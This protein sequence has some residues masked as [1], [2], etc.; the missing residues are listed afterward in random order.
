VVAAPGYGKTTAVRAA[1]P[2]AGVHWHQGAVDDLDHWAKDFGRLPGQDWIVL[3]DVPRL[4]SDQ[5][6]RL[7]A[8]VAR[9]PESVRV[10]VVSRWPL[11][12]AVSGWRG[13]GMLAEVGSTDLALTSAAVAAVLAHDYGLD[14][15]TLARQVHHA[16]TGWPALVHL[17]GQALGDG[18]ALTEV[19]VPGTPLTRYVED[20]VLEPLPATVV[21]LVRRLTHLAPV[22]ASLCRAIGNPNA[23]PALDL[24]TRIG[25]MQ[26]GRLV[27]V[28]ARVARPTRRS[29][30]AVRRDLLAAAWY[31][32]HG[33]PI[34]AALAYRR[35][36]AP[37]DVARILAGR[38]DELVASGA[39]AA[40]IELIQAL[41]E[42]LV[43]RKL[44]L[45]LAEA[46]CTDG[47]AAAALAI[48][49]ALADG[50]NRLEPDLAWRTGMVHYL[51][52]EPQTALDTYARAGNS[53]GGS[54]VDA[55]LLLAWSATAYWML[56]AADQ[57]LWCAR[58]AC[59][60]AGAALAP[61][62]QAAAHVALALCLTLAGDLA[63]A[64]EHY[65][66]GLRYAEA[67]GDLVQLSRIHLNRSHHLLAE[68]RYPDAVR[69]AGLAAGLAD[70]TGPPGLL[71]VA[72]CNEAEALTRLGWYDQAVE[73]LERVVS[74]TQRT[75][76]RR[77]AGALHGL[78]EVHRRRGAVQQARGLYEEAIR[79]SRDG[80]ERQ[81]LVPALAG[82]ARLLAVEDPS[83]AWILAK[84]AM[85]GAVGSGVVP[86]LL[87]GGWVELA[88][89]EPAE[90]A[91]LADEAVVRARRRRERSWL[92][93][94]LE[95]QAQVAGDVDKA[96]TSLV[97]AIGIWRDGGASD[98]ADRLL[99][100]LGRL[101]AAS[102]DHRLE[103]K[104]AAERLA[105]AGVGGL[106]DAGG[107]H[108][109]AGGVVV[110]VLGRFEVF[111]NGRLVPASEWQSRKARDL[112]RI[113]VSR[114]GS[115]LPRSELSELLWPDD[116]PAR[117][118][119][120]L[121]VLLSIVRTV[122][123]RD[124]LVVDAASVA[125]DLGQLRV[126]VEDFLTDVA[127]GIRLRD[128]GATAGARSLL[129]AAEQS[130]LGDAFGDDPYDDWAVALREEARSA[131]LQTLRVL[132]ELD[133]AAGDTEQAAYYLRRLL[134]NDPYDEAAHRR[135]VEV[136]VAGGRHGEARRAFDRYSRAMA[137]IGVSPPDETVLTPR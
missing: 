20:E 18:A 39:A 132:A 136:L 89:G 36:N 99:I 17:A 37:A 72:L 21:R 7:L 22:S 38:G 121:S 85:D 62:A 124:V 23:D 60:Q 30:A 80:G 31:E 61:R 1:L 15:P 14:D 10:A 48:L 104:L 25:V 53:N 5:T 26:G 78:G 54:P 137:G 40:V 55:A 58:R 87:A 71:A 44:R 65:A 105:A 77:V 45:L 106:A 115:P 92:A 90:V 19:A 57:G 32:D 102:A 59:E 116:D 2:T 67:A 86:A 79:I 129:A 16:T 111:V 131:Y 113:L 94:A 42:T 101:P 46:L 93:E 35:S 27:P 12:A 64:D 51:R 119:H 52:G 127:H 88:R 56:G 122:S 24:L 49:D 34:A 81:A 13:Q 41:P 118:A 68:A 126:D 8:L 11:A 117:T 75:G 135:L 114:R 133:R 43:D 95:L 47:Q 74:L 84:E 130:Y 69:L 76:S 123:G 98:D 82:L 4:T 120:R 108:T 9:L 109:A 134:R 29:S 70:V 6:R 33:P 112:L 96:R 110:R 91:R 50:S 3:D 73:R 28:I 100:A 97:E 107:N 125:L 66:H 83:T 63:G 128:G 103:A